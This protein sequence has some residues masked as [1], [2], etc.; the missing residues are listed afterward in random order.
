[1]NQCSQYRIDKQATEITAL[2]M[3]RVETLISLANLLYTMPS[4]MLSFFV[5][6]A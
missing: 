4:L 5:T 2:E 3:C 6:H 1:M